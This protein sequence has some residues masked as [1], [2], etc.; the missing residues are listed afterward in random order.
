MLVGVQK[1]LTQKDAEKDQ[2]AA[3]LNQTRQEVELLRQ[4]YRAAQQ[5]YE[6]QA[7]SCVP[8]Y[9]TLLCLVSCA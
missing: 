8:P 2:V 4:Q 7:R 6:R 1:Q 3:R 5:S 9:A